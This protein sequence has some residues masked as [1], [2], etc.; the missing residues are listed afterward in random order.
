M[1]ASNESGDD[2]DEEENMQVVCGADCYSPSFL[3]WAARFQTGAPRLV[4][5]TEVNSQD[6]SAGAINSIAAAQ[7]SI[8]KAI[9]CQT[10]IVSLFTKGTP[11]LADR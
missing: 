5:T 8:K 6:A 7:E 4:T 10:F 9:G 3:A 2:D 11:S 1:I